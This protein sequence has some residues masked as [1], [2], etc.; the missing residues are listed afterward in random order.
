MLPVMETRAV[1]CKLRILSKMLPKIVLYVSCRAY[2]QLAP[3]KR[4]EIS[5]NFHLE[6]S[7]NLEMLVS[8]EL[9]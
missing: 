3:N 5:A 7:R 6:I 9:L 4:T 1:S 8:S 2:S